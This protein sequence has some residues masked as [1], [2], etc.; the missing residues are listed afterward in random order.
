MLQTEEETKEERNEALWLPVS[1]QV[2][3][4]LSSGS[5]NIPGWSD[6]SH[7]MGDSLLP[8][9]RSDD[10][11]TLADVNKP[12]S[13]LRLDSNPAQLKQREKL[14]HNTTMQCVSYAW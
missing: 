2:Q 3:Q 8:V 4:S 7:M 10:K 11:V 12:G 6:A 9:F 5:G 14:A 1:S 13:A